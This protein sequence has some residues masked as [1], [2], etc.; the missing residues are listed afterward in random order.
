MSMGDSPMLM[1]CIDIPFQRIEE[2]FTGIRRVSN[3]SAGE[4]EKS[5][6]EKDIEESSRN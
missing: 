2:E 3:S 4:A 5:K 6:S 1:K